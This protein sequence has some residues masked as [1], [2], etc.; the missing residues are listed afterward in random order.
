[1]RVSRKRY[2]VG[3]L[4][5]PIS[6]QRRRNNIDLQSLVALKPLT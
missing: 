3:E 5:L 4:N 1:M 2:G 6:P